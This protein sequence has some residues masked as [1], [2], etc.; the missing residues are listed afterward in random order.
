MSTAVKRKLTTILCADVKGYTQL[1]EADEVATL[2]TLKAY[3]EAMTGLIER[4]HGRVVNTWGDG[5]V[6]EFASVVEAVQCA[7]EVQRELATRN[8]GQTDGRRM[9]F[10]IGINLGDVMIDG[11][12][13]YGEGVNI[14]ARLEA[15]ADPGGIMISDTVHVQVR[16]KLSLGYEFVGA[17][18][19]KNVSENVPVY[20]VKLDAHTARETGR[21]ETRHEPERPIEP[22]AAAEA[23]RPPP[24]R[25]R[26][27]RTRLG[28]AVILGAFLFLINLL[29]LGD[30]G[31]WW[32]YWPGLVITAFIAL[33]ALM[34]FGL[35]TVGRLDGGALA[36]SSSP[37]GLRTICM[38][39]YGL[40]A[41]VF[42]TGVSPVIGVIIAHFRKDG[43]AGTIYQSHLVWQIRTFWFGLAGAVV[44]GALAV[45][46]IGIPILV[47][48]LAWS[49]YRVVK[50]FLLLTDGKPID[51]PAALI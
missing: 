45:V 30:G 41:A 1:M 17:K 35:P 20:R 10:R 40:Y 9:S 37:G 19:V 14:A 7:A 33:D 51:D 48:A 36:A 49:L 28:V 38:V 22:A 25:V 4:H 8:A 46:A 12:D 27:F 23:A 42:L 3:R 24:A 39:V 2:A 13:L 50:G 21:A 31:D 47:A 32:F 34:V 43:A 15:L 18:H 26:R 29:T 5:L 6:A 16:N 11:S 44:G